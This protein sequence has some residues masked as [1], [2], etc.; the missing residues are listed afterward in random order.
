MGLEKII[1]SAK[2]SCKSDLVIKN[3]QIINVLTEEIY[4]ADVAITDGIIVGV[5]NGY[6][7][8]TEINGEGKFLSPSFIDGHVHIESSMLS[9]GEFAR[10]V[11]HYSCRSA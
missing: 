10:M 9:P 7:G 3:I 1:N 6:E 5:G 8:Q 2:S 11:N 4:K